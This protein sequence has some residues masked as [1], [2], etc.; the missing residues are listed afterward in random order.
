MNNTKR[1]VYIRILRNC[2]VLDDR[3]EPI[4]LKKFQT[5][6]FEIFDAHERHANGYSTELGGWVF[7]IMPHWYREV[8][9]WVV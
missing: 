1:E 2:T 5:I 4:R 3:G 8:E 9:P 6:K 7:R